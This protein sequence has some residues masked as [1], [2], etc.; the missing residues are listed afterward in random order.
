[1]N[2]DKKIH[3]T[4]LEKKEEKKRNLIEHKIRE[5]RLRPIVDNILENDDFMFDLI[6]ESKM[7]AKQGINEQE[8]GSH[9]WDMV[10]NNYG[11]TIT[12]SLIKYGK[13]QFIKQLFKWG[14]LKPDSWFATVIRT[15]VGNLEFADIPK[16]TNCSFIVNHLSVTLADAA[17]L[18]IQQKIG[19]AADTGIASIFRSALISTLDKSTLAE[20]M[21]DG[22]TKIICPWLTKID[23][24]F[25]QKADTMKQKAIS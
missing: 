23:D 24:S 20:A 11:D 1:M 19:G 21:K 4:L 13:E 9:F 2:L 5:D 25:K 18:K 16:L 3:Q 15:F 10:K 8:T 6:F 12:N 7:L 22:L 14:G 17:L